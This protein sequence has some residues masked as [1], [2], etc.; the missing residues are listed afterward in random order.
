MFTPFTLSNLLLQW[1]QGSRPKQTVRADGIWAEKPG[2]SVP[3]CEY[4]MVNK[5]FQIVCN[6]CLGMIYITGQAGN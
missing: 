1:L 4:L 2:V 5:C 6:T 3:L